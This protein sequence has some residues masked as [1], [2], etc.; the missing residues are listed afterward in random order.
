MPR[1]PLA[2]VLV[3][4]IAR[5]FRG[6]LGYSIALRAPVARVVA[7]RLPATIELGAAALLVG[8]LVLRLRDA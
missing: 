1:R 3:S 8:A 5:A 2:V 6:D 4:D 7:Q